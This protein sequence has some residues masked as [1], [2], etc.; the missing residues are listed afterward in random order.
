MFAAEYTLP[1]QEMSVTKD[2]KVYLSKARKKAN[3]F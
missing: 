2:G 3:R 1:R